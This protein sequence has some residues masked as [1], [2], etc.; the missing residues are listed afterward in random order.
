VAAGIGTAAP[1]EDPG[2]EPEVLEAVRVALELGADING[3]DKNGD[4]AMHGAAS[5]HVPSVVEFLA[6]SGARVEVWNQKNKEGFTPL[7]IAEGVH[8]GMNILS[9]PVTAAAIRK[10]LQQ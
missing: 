9:S 3:V 2:T 8:R 4:T 1:G 5:K 6:R 10:V 7:R